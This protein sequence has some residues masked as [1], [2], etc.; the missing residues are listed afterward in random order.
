MTDQ[1][2]FFA[3]LRNLNVVVG[4][5]EEG[6]LNVEAPAG[7]L[8]PDIVGQLRERKQE[9]VAYLGQL[10]GAKAALGRIAPAAPAE[11]YPLSSSQSRLWVINEVSGGDA[12]YNIPVCSE[13]DG[14]VEP[15]GYE[16]ALRRVIERHEILRTVFR[17]DAHGSVRQWVLPAKDV[18]FRLPCHDLRNAPDPQAV[19]SRLVREDAGRPF[20]L[21]QGPLFRVMLFRLPEEKYAFYYNMHHIISD[22]WSINVLTRELAAGYEAGRLGVPAT[23]PPLAIQYKDY[24]AWQREQLQ[25]GPYRQHRQYWQQQ[26]AGEL[27]VLEL[28]TAKARPAVQ[29]HEGYALRT[30][31]GPEPVAALRTLTNRHNATLYMGLVAVLKVLLYRY[32]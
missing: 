32:T 8:T 19:V 28:P 14:A 9:L 6:N 13:L 23:L 2:K 31:I 30:V 26:L 21:R 12:V 18:D 7:V 1:T 10:Q 4:L 16:A 11:S 15:A 5:D 3:L 25:S 20:D 22:G 27:P 29:T 17:E 24:A